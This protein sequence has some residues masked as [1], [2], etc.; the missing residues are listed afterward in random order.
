[1]FGD[2]V[3][4]GQNFDSITKDDRPIRT[5]RQLTNSWPSLSLKYPLLNWCQLTRGLNDLLVVEND[6]KRCRDANPPPREARCTCPRAR[7]TR[8]DARRCNCGTRLRVCACVRARRSESVA[9]TCKRDYPVIW[10]LRACVRACVRALLGFGQNCAR[11]RSIKPTGNELPQIVASC[12]EMAVDVRRLA[13]ALMMRSA[14]S[15]SPIIS[16]LRN[17]VS[18]LLETP[19][20]YDPARKMNSLFR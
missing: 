20:S 18:T 16:H 15:E 1:M 7:L 6:E 12:R 19:A 11:L 17:P 4:T 14:D 10:I 9:F 8:D 2:A 13:R 3:A 5:R